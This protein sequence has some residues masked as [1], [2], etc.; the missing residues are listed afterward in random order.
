MLT[1]DATQSNKKLIE[2]E[3][4]AKRKTQELHTEQLRYYRNRLKDI[5]QMVRIRTKASQSVNQDSATHKPGKTT[6]RRASRRRAS[7]ANSTS[8]DGTNVL[9]RIKI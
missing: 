3:F 7:L 6:Q 2:K 8:K 4:L 5:K 9:F 1:Q